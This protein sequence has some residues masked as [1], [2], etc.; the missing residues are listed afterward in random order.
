[1]SRILAFFRTR[2]RDRNSAPQLRD[3][4]F[5][6]LMT[7]LATLIFCVVFSVRSAD[8]ASE[9]VMIGLSVFMYA[10]LMRIVGRWRVPFIWL[11][12]IWLV[13]F[14]FH[15][16]LNGFLALTYGLR[17]DSNIILRSI[18]NSQGDEF[19]EGFLHT[20]PWVIIVAAGG[21]IWLGAMLRMTLIYGARARKF[22]AGPP[23]F[24]QI[25]VAFVATLA[26]F[27]ANFVPA[28]RMA[29]P[30]ALW[31]KH[32]VAYRELA[33]RQE[34][35]RKLVDATRSRV[36]AWAPKYFGPKKAT[37]VFVIGESTSRFNWSLYGYARKTTPELDAMRDELVVFKDVISA[38]GS[39]V[40]SMERMLTGATMRDRSA[41]LREPDVLLLAQAAGYKVFWLSNQNDR[42]ISRLF[43]ETADKSVFINRGDAESVPLDEELAP[44]YEAALA[45]PAPLKLIILHPMGAHPKY[46]RRVP[47]GFDAFSDADDEVEQKM[48]EL[49]RLFLVRSARASYDNAILYQDARLADAIRRLKENAQ[50][51]GGSARFLYISDHAQEVGHTR[52]FI[53]HDAVTFVGYSVPMFYWQNS[54]FPQEEKALL[55]G[56]AYQADRL[57][58]TLLPLLFIKTRFD[59]AEDDI[60]NIEHFAPQKRYLEDE[61]Y[62]PGVPEV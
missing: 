19:L 1:M 40:P 6:T 25:A 56:R 14:A 21:F 4:V 7:L 42:Q 53:G 59:R 34:S 27:A 57:E 62:V 22:D 33:D 39:T 52:D 36:P 18:S 35:L 50:K 28:L 3:A 12:S 51:N 48:E 30:F 41:F 8:T 10:Q 31:T 15:L 17:A 20:A 54:P 37:F 49:G 46:D 23:N 16:W 26:F 60:F 11:N 5:M 32:I 38:G 61:D 45:D 55:E 44:A 29:N 2:L 58:H 13:F 9:L 43:A 47:E 24:G